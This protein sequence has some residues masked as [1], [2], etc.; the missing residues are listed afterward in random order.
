[1]RQ[2]KLKF[3]KWF[4]QIENE[5]MVPFLIVGIMVICGFGVISYYNGYT[6]QRRGQKEMAAVLFNEINRDINYLDGCL[7]YTSRCV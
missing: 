7:L 2:L 5:V 1:M 3:E 6:I 4:F